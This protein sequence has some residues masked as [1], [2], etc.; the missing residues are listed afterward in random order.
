MEQKK[1]RFLSNAYFEEILQRSG[2]SW[3]IGGTV[4]FFLASFTLY[5]FRWAAHE[6]VARESAVFVG[7]TFMG[8]INGSIVYLLPA[9]F[10]CI[11][12][13]FVVRTIRAL[14]VT[15]QGAGRRIAFL[16]SFKGAAENEA[17]P[18]MRC[19]PPVKCAIFF[20]RVEKTH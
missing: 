11:T 7:E 8:P 5:L 10:S 14:L 9:L 17:E 2:A 1:V 4:T 15:L 3:P 6:S 20:Q 13:F 12:L 19:V 16:V 18:R